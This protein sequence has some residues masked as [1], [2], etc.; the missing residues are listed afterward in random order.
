M[1]LPKDPSSKPEPAVYPV[2]VEAY[3]LTDPQ[4]ENLAS[5]FYG[6]VLTISGGTVSD[7]QTSIEFAD[8]HL[9]AQF[10]HAL[11]SFRR[12]SGTSPLTIPPNPS[13]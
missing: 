11:L 3:T 1:A 8:I 2:H 7:P 4:L 10:C 12:P 9:V 13:P 5:E 6:R